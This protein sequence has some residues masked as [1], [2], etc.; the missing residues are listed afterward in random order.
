MMASVH[1][2]TRGKLKFMRAFQTLGVSNKRGGAARD[3]E[4]NLEKM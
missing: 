1:I 2:M 3:E 4:R